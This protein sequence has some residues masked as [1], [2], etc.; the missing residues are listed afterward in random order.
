MKDVLVKLYSVIHNRHVSGY[1]MRPTQAGILSPLITSHLVMMIPPQIL[2]RTR[3]SVPAPPDELKCCALGFCPSERLNTDCWWSSV[4]VCAARRL[5][6]SLLPVT[7]PS[8]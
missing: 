1:L 7:G 5:L 4:S 6:A 8:K 2:R 3:V